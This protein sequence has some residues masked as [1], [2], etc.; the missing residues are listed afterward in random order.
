MAKNHASRTVAVR[1]SPLASILPALLLTLMFVSAWAHAA[2]IDYVYDDL[3]RLRAVDDPSSDTA[4]YNYDAVGNLLSI[5]RQSSSV[6]S[7]IDFPAL[8]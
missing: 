7:I 5:S 6:V 1:L 2:E 4:V 3:G 8:F